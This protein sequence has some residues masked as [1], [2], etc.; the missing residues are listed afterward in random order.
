MKMTGE[1]RA[2]GLTLF[3]RKEACSLMKNE[4]EE[5][6]NI[7]N[8]I[9]CDNNIVLSIKKL[10]DVDEFRA[11]MDKECDAHINHPCS[12]CK[13]FDYCNLNTL[14][15]RERFVIDRLNRGLK[16]IEKYNKAYEKLK[17]SKKG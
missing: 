5:I 9:E 11:E 2:I 12:E 14:Y 15:F 7:E 1:S 13:F 3:P 6:K 8:T 17:E 16:F 4:L 10:K